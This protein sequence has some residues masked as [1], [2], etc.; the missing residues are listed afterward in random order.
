MAD[1]VDKCERWRCCLPAETAPGGHLSR[2]P[3]VSGLL[4][5]TVLALWRLVRGLHAPP[6]V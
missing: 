4:A 5:S 1:V 6:Q 3:G 2:A